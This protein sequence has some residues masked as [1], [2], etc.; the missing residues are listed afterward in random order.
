MKNKLIMVIALLFAGLAFFLNWQYLKKERDKL[1][2]GHEMVEIIVAKRDLPSMT[3]LTLDDLVLNNVFKS[4]VGQNVFE[5]GDLDLLL[6]KKLLYP[7]RRKD[8]ILWTQVD[9]PQRVGTGL[10]AAIERGKR[11]LSLSIAGAQGV[12]GMVQP[13]DH[14][15]I[16]GTFTFPSPTNPAQVES[17]TLMLLQNVTVLAAG[18][19]IAGQ[20]DGNDRRS[21]NGYSS[22]TFA[23]TPMEAEILVFAQQTRGQLYLSLRNPN[24]RD[25]VTNIDSVNFDYIAGILQ[26]LNE[27]RQQE[28]R[29]NPR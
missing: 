9:M 18:N 20:A 26:Q 23:V 2:K 15:D 28:I 12:A 16:M 14:V 27:Q 25:A 24:D 10:S 11:A 29:S 6:G 22:V 4:A 3:V 17:V 5:E 7:V 1:I 8:P 19:R 13:N 21:G